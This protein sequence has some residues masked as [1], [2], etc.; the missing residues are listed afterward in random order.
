MISTVSINYQIFDTYSGQSKYFNCFDA[1][2]SSKWLWNSMCPMFSSLLAS[3]FQCSSFLMVDIY[4]T[5]RKYFIT[6]IKLFTTD[7]FIYHIFYV[8]KQ[9]YDAFSICSV[10]MPRL[11]SNKL[12]AILLRFIYTPRRLSISWTIWC[13]F[14][15]RK[16]YTKPLIHFL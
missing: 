11:V 5:T 3:S 16:R 13:C 1:N 12:W 7:H 8:F 14:D 6:I 9:L 10:L 15:W 2:K 4:R